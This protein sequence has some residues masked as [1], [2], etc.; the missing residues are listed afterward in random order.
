MHDFLQKANTGNLKVELKEQEL[1][2]I[3]KE[4]KHANQ[5]TITAIAGASLVISS[6]ILMGLDG[7]APS[8]LGD[9]PLG[10]WL[11]GGAGA[12]LLVFAFWRNR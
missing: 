11:L 5:R 7:Y 6:M 9:A 3:R 1:E 2:K 12:W 8:M 4:I 10:T